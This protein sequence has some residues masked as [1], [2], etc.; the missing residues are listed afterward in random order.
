MFNFIRDM[1]IGWIVFTPEGKKVANNVVALAYKNIKKNV[2]KSKQYQEIVGLKDIFM[3]EES[4]EKNDT[5]RFTKHDTRT[6][7]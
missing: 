5:Y 7:D 4:E 2:V 1:L 6:K 3:K